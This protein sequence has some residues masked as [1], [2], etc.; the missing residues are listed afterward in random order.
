MQPPAGAQLVESWIL[1]TS[2]RMTDAVGYPEK[3]WS[4]EPFRFRWKHSR[5]F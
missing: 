2:P 5:R 3:S 1:G 4:L